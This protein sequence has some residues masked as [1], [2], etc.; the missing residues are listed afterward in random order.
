MDFALQTA[1]RLVR[2]LA[3]GW[4]RIK[5]P[6]LFRCAAR[7]DASS[8]GRLSIRYASGIERTLRLLKAM[9]TGFTVSGWKPVCGPRRILVN[10]CFLNRNKLRAWILL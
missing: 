8:P 5:I 10:A 9:S 4:P 7:Y 2:W 1:Q 3:I 6:A